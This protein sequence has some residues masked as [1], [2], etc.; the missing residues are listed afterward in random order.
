MDDEIDESRRLNRGGVCRLWA[1][2]GLCTSTLCK[3]GGGANRL[4]APVQRLT[5]GGGDVYYSHTTRF[6]GL[7]FALNL[8]RDREGNTR[9]FIGGVNC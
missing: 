9:F 6:R 3:R 2:C 5:P 7:N 8:R 1:L 4:W